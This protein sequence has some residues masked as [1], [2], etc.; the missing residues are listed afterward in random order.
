M[1]K[2]SWI[3]SL[4]VLMGS[5]SYAQNFETLTYFES[6]SLSLELDLFMPDMPDQSKNIPLVVYVHGGGFMGGDRT[7]GHALA[8][9]LVKEGIACASISY[10]L[11]MKGKSFSCD[12]I[13]SEK[14][15]AIQIAASQLWHATAFLLDNAEKYHFDRDQIFIG[16]SSAGA[17]TVLHGAYFDRQKMQLFGKAL[18]EDFR[19]AG[20]ISG[21]GA[22]MDLNMIT[23]ENAIPT[24]LFHG[25]AD[26]L[27]PYATAAHHYCPP[28]ATGW[29]MFFGSYTIAQHMEKLGKSCEFISFT[30]GGHY[31]AGAFIHRDQERTIAFIQRVLASDSFT[32]YETKEGKR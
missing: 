4:L 12:G 7:G 15:K 14:V 19:Y 16:G 11:Y 22:V 3:F 27:V 1:K 26:N 29:L 8:K 5:W 25:D 2:I 6:D 30:N 28:T 23:Q 18:P 20:I 9:E 13:T 10:T 31:Y 17:E 21:A 32:I 24:M